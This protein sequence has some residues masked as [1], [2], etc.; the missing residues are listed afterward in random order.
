MV[1][2]I[3][4]SL[5]KGTIL[6][7]TYEIQTVIGEGGFGITYVARDLH[8]QQIFAIKEYFIYLTK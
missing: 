8:T 7:N 6:N 5:P 3:S 2:N 4:H 1:R